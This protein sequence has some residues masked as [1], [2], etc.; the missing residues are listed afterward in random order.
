MIY[1]LGDGGH[2]GLVLLDSFKRQGIKCKLII[3]NNG[4]R[5]A[6]DFSLG[7]QI[8]H[9]SLYVSRFLKSI[10][11]G[12]KLKVFNVGYNVG[13]VLKSS[14]NDSERQVYFEKTRGTGLAKNN[15]CLSGGKNFI[16]G[17]DMSDGSI[18][19]TLLYKHKADIIEAKVNEIYVYDKSL[20]MGYND[21]S[22]KYDKLISTI[23]LATLQQ[24]VGIHYFELLKRTVYFTH[25]VE[26]QPWKH[27]YYSHSM[28]TRNNFDY[29]Y[30]INSP[31]INRATR[32]VGGQVVVES[33]DATT[34]EGLFINYEVKSIIACGSQIQTEVRQADYCGIA[35]V[36]RFAQYDHSVKLNNVIDLWWR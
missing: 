10:G 4:V 21:D 14:I 3:T 27:P 34:D 33:N 29:I 12:L 36:G 8:L 18:K 11:S 9:Q 32:L 19:N 25:F 2:T 24:L 17:Y 13:G 15:S 20:V 30:Y 28:F 16:L 6:G 31:R 35:L 5:P 1:I 23:D 26:M 22:L 7:P